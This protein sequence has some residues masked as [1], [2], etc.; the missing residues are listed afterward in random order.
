MFRV[1]DQFKKHYIITLLLVF[2]GISG[3]SQGKIAG[4]SMVAPPQEFKEDPI[5]P[6]KDVNANWVKEKD[7]KAYSVRTYQK[8]LGPSCFK[9]IC[10]MN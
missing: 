8:S 3:V 5:P 4:I 10:R 6:I 7:C 9:L 1:I 2:V